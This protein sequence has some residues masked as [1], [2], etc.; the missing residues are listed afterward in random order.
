MILSL[1]VCHCSLVNL[2]C[3]WLR[4]KMTELLQWLFI[5]GG[6][7]SWKLLAAALATYLNIND[8]R[9]D[10]LISITEIYNIDSTSAL[11]V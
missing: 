5:E 7:H 4:P 3:E 6:G 2:D 8:A 10:Q 9:A 1:A 11:L